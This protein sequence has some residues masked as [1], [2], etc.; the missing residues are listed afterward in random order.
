MAG[1]ADKDWYPFF[2][3]VQ[4]MDEEHFLDMKQQF[5]LDFALATHL[6]Q[7]LFDGNDCLQLVRIA[8]NTLLSP[9]RE[10]ESGK[11]IVEMKVR[12]N[13]DFPTDENATGQGKLHKASYKTGKKFVHECA[14]LVS[15]PNETND[16]QVNLIKKGKLTG[17]IDDVSC[18][19][20]EA[21]HSRVDRTALFQADLFCRVGDALSDPWR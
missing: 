9:F 6:P 13:L 16:G 4:V 19:A 14:R 11:V 10:I 7:P 12:A 8:P 17:L 5:V 2:L 1:T 21:E 18:P 20:L 15:E 3:R